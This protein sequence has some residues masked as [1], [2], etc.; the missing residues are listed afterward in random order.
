M[1]HR[2]GGLLLIACVVI[3]LAVPTSA[4][5]R[6]TWKVKNRS[7]HVVGTLVTS[8]WVLVKVKN[9]KG[10]RLGEL[11]QGAHPSCG[12]Y[13]GT[14][15]GQEIAWSYLKVLHPESSQR[16]I[17]RAVRKGDHWVIK[18]RVKS[19]FRK[20]GTVPA[21]CPNYFALGGARLLLW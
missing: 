9:K 2:S 11:L 17:G 10:V 19:V 16:V 15:S 18:K 5:A 3:A 4:L 13:K 21:S 1:R 6:Q 8:D 14:A 20:V 12:V 7:G